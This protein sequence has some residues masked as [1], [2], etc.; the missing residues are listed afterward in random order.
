[1]GQNMCYL[2]KFLKKIV[3]LNKM[4]ALGIYGAAKTSM[5]LL[6]HYYHYCYFGLS[7]PCIKYI[8]VE[9]DV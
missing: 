4:V 8:N 1:M 3:P 9:T 7:N 6:G 2:G 5:M